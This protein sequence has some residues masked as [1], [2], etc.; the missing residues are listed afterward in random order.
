MKNFFVLAGRFLF[1]GFFVYNGILH[2]T[3]FAALLAY[4]Q[5][6]G[7]PFAEIA[8]AIAGAFLTLGGIS[9]LLGYHTKIGGL[10]LLAFLIPASFTMHNFWME[11]DPANVQIQMSYFLRNLAFI[12]AILMSF[13]E[14]QWTFSWNTAA[15]T[16]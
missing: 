5:T 14:V 15:G 13:R 8:V 2:F 1:G 7:V 4:S 11:S 9:Y 16:A 6:K 12:G 3:N 10:L